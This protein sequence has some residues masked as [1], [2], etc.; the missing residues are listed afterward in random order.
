MHGSA[1]NRGAGCSDWRRPHCF[2]RHTRLLA[3]GQRNNR[4]DRSIDYE[5][6]V[7]IRAFMTDH[8][9]KG[10]F[11]V[12]KDKPPDRE[13][14]L[15]VQQIQLFAVFLKAWVDYGVAHG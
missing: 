3:L 7:V 2:E 11:V 14:I 15:Y 12:I 5:H 6:A 4:V 9:E 8:M 1:M 10:Q 13:Q